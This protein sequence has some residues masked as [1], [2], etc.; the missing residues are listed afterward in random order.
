MSGLV[1]VRDRGF[2][3]GDIPRRF[4]GVNYGNWMLIEHYMLGLPWTEYKM[5]ELFRAMLGEKAFQAFFGTFMDL[6]A[7]DRDFAFM[8]D[9]GFN[10]VQLPFNYRHFIADGTTRG[11]DNRGFEY[12]DRFVDLCGRHDMYAILSLHAAPGCAV[13]D[14]NAESAYGEAFLWEHEHFQDV[15]AEIWRGMAGRYRG[16]PAVFGYEILNEPLAPNREAFDRFNRR[17]LR[18]IREVD[19]DHIVVI[20]GDR[21]GQNPASLADDLFDDPQTIPCMHHYMSSDPPFGQLES[22]PGEHEG[23]H[24]G[25]DELVANARRRVDRERIPRPVLA[26]ECGASMRGSAARREAALAMFDDQLGYYNQEGFVWN[27]WAFKGLGVHGLLYPGSDTPWQR[28]L[29][30][31]QVKQLRSAYRECVPG[32]RT[33]LERRVPGLNQEDMKLFA[34]QCGH[35]WD[36]LAL[37]KVLELLKPCSLRELEEMARSFAF[38][39]CEVQKEKHEIVCR[40]AAEMRDVAP[41]STGSVQ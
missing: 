18:T 34:H 16:N 3:V 2:V 40:R 7:T 31:P 28:F 41:D 12:V 9:C 24:Y 1:Q 20:S 6:Y 32:F 10:L 13:R 36:A 39:N 4:C 27:F 17:M 8:R 21:W 22:Y 38:E 23:K 15:T 14:W 37:P 25:R 35:H 26:G 19:S 33:A 11:F 29:C 30:R 5:R